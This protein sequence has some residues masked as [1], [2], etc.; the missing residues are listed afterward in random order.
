M[1]LNP[2]LTGYKLNI[3]VE[4]LAK[5]GRFTKAYS[6]IESNFKIEPTQPPNLDPYP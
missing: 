5:T 2:N 1:N 3:A 4:T 6:L